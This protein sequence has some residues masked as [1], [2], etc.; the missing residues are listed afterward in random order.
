MSQRLLSPRDLLVANVTTATGKSAAKKKKRGSVEGEPNECQLLPD[1]FHPGPLR[2]DRSASGYCLAICCLFHGRVWLHREANTDGAPDAA[3]L[4]LAPLI[5]TLLCF[6][7]DSF[8]TTARER[9]ISTGRSTVYKRLSLPPNLIFANIVVYFIQSVIAIQYNIILY[10]IWDKK[11]K[12]IN[13][14]LSYIFII[15]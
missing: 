3:T 11:T 2:T 13:I 5:Q 7:G 8:E 9:F 14:L 6:F 4:P 1:N 10:N 15:K 12:N